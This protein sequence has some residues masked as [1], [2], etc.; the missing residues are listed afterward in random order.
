MRI[1][2]AGAQGQLARALHEGAPRD[3]SQLVVTL[4]RPAFD[5]LNPAAF[6]PTVRNLAPDLIVNA[7]AYTAVDNAERDPATAYAVNRDGAGAL[8]AIAAKHDCPIIHLSTDYVFDGTKDGRYREDDATGPTGV[9]GR[10]KLEGE[11]A[12]AEANGR[13]IVLRTAWVYAAYGSN[14]VGTMLRLAKERPQLRVV[15]DQRGNPTYAP[16]LAEAIFAIA[17]RLASGSAPAWGIYH[18]A[19]SGD[20]N[21]HEFA[22]A[23]V[24]AAGVLGIAAVPV[25]PI[26][27]AEFPTAARRPAN[28]CLDCS[29]LQRTFGVRLPHWREGLEACIA[30]LAGPA[31][32]R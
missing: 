1:L 14:F 16:H 2:V 3:R 4:G 5:L 24:E 18:A 25:V 21:W 31:K 10:S 11:M 9:Y 7:A 32:S 22:T 29:K 19:G 30:Q 28:S 26:T 23:I 15:A 12:V 8:A 6:A 13:H 17:A 27:T 20:T